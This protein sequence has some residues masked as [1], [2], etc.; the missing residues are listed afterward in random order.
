VAVLK[1]SWKR[2]TMGLILYKPDGT[3][4]ARCAGCRQ[5]REIP[6][7]EKPTIPFHCASCL[8]D[9]VISAILRDGGKRPRWA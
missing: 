4:K 9:L 3:M 5:L 6:A 7:G 1:R 8:K 2:T